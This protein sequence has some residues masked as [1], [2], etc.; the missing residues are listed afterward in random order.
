[1]SVCA[2]S[3]D[4][5]CMCHCQYHYQSMQSMW[6]GGRTPPRWPSLRRLRASARTRAGVGSVSCCTTR[7]R[8]GPWPKPQAEPKPL[9]CPVCFSAF[10][11]DAKCGGSSAIC[12]RILRACDPLVSCGVAP[13]LT[14]S[15][16]CWS[17]A[18]PGIYCIS[19][20]SDTPPIFLFFVLALVS[21]STPKTS[22]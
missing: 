14:R 22:L 20:A 21:M 2:H 3:R 16:A 12:R 11:A 15:C 7:P 1:M 17:F 4:V 6:R 19:C 8:R 10:S 5:H 18:D 13:P 9:P